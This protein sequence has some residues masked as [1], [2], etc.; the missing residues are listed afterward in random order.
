[1]EKIF[2]LALIVVLLAVGYNFGKPYLEGLFD[3]VDSLGT[4]G[5]SCTRGIER[6]RDNFAS[7]MSKVTPPVQIERWNSDLAMSRG[8]LN[9]ART[10]CECEGEGCDDA[11]AAL[12]ALERLMTDWDDAIQR[13][14]A[15][16]L[17]GARGLER[18]DELVQEAKSKGV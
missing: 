3:E 7:K 6:A 18:V 12:D 9:Q 8:R 15:P 13:E 11:R 2:K 17:N 16:P 14:G 4:G 5:G 10:A 1:M